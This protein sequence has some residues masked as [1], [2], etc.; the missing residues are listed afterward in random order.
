MEHRNAPAI[1]NASSLFTSLH[2][3]TDNSN[4]YQV[5]NLKLRDTS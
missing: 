4:S 3:F 1:I 5:K 2:P